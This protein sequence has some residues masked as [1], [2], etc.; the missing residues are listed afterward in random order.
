M[1]TTLVLVTLIGFFSTYGLLTW[2]FKSFLI[3]DNG[4]RALKDQ[5]SLFGKGVLAFA[6]FFTFSSGLS[7]VISPLG[8]SNPI[9]VFPKA[10]FI[11]CL[12]ASVRFYLMWR[13]L[14]NPFEYPFIDYVKTVF[15]RVQVLGVREH[16]REQFKLPENAIIFRIPSC[17]DVG[18]I[19]NLLNNHLVAQGHYSYRAGAADSYEEGSSIV[20]GTI[21]NGLHVHTVIYSVGEDAL[22][23]Y[24]KKKPE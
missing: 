21:L 16:L 13:K 7:F 3:H 20:F 23:V 24:S 22:I 17:Q 8:W 2:G 14:P 19:A 18:V 5:I 12:T 10:V 15:N 11:G 4:S 6:T 9:D 1:N